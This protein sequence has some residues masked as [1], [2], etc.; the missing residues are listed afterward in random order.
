[1]GVG[2]MFISCRV[3]IFIF[4]F[5]H[6]MFLSRK[7]KCGIAT[8]KSAM[9]LRCSYV[10]YFLKNGEALSKNGIFLCLGI[11]SWCD[12]NVSD[13]QLEVHRTKEYLGWFR[14]RPLDGDVAL[15]PVIFCVPVVSAKKKEH[16]KIVGFAAKMY[17]GLHFPVFAQLK[18]SA[19]VFGNRV[20]NCTREPLHLQ[21]CFQ[22]TVTWLL[23]F[24]GTAGKGMCWPIMGKGTDT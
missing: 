11:N 3:F 13:V 18:R 19:F 5:I 1:M 10:L 14:C 23:R 20:G 6:F 4:R 2:N 15:R 12:Q 7:D 21:Y 22:H 24:E 8:A 17:W 16:G 9:P